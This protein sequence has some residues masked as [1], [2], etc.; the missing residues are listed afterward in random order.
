MA[1][2]PPLGGEPEGAEGVGAVVVF[3]CA[4]LEAR[5]KAKANS[6]ARALGCFIAARRGRL[7]PRLRGVCTTVLEN[8]AGLARERERQPTMRQ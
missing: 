1:P 4:W 5:S 6:R 2:E 8:E 3:C 7:G